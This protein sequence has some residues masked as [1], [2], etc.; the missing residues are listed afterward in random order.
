MVTLEEILQ[1]HFNCKVPF[2]KDGTLTTTGEKAVLGLFDLL[3][4]LDC[5]GILESKEAVREIN[6]ILTNKFYN[7]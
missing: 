3:D 7:P 5:C 2:R 4:D 6:N 1:K